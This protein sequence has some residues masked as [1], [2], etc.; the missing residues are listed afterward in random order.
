[1]KPPRGPL[2]DP[3]FMLLVALWIPLTVYALGLGWLW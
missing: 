2:Q 1:M 3:V